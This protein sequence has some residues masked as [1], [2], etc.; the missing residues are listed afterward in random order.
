MAFAVFTAAASAARPSPR[1]ASFLGKSEEQE[2]LASLSQ[3]SLTS[4][5]GD[6]L[7]DFIVSDQGADSSVQQRQNAFR[8]RIVKFD[9]LDPD[10]THRCP[11][12]FAEPDRRE[13]REPLP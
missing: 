6:R 13:H 8:R 1:Q 11:H 4:M 7:H 2:T 12:L 9:P 3:S 10:G 5:S